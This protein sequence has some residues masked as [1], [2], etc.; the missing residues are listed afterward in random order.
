MHSL[1]NAYAY[2][3]DAANQPTVPQ[4][5]DIAGDVT[6]AREA[7]GFVTYVR[8]TAKQLLHSQTLMTSC[9]KYLM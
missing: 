6:V 8:R 4:V 3:F 5:M 2:L 1:H 9:V 7:A